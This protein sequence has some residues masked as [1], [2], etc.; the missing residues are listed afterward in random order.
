MAKQELHR[1][2]EN[3]MDNCLASNSETGGVGCDNMTM[4]V[5][6]LLRGRTK[7]E[8]YEEVARRASNGDG[9]CAPPEYGKSSAP[10]TPA[11][12]RDR[13]LTSDDGVAEFRGPGVHHSFE[14]SA[15]EFDADL[16][17]RFAHHPTGR[18]ILLG[19]GTEVLTD[20][21]D[22]EMFD[23]DDEDKDLESQV[24]R[25]QPGTAGGGG[26]GTK[27]S[28][29]GPS[30][31]AREGTPTA[32]TKAETEQSP[33]PRRQQTPERDSLE[34]DAVPEKLFTPPKSELNHEKTRAAT[35]KPPEQSPSPINET[36]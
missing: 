27:A 30:K 35:D 26:G 25:G 9:P 23:H 15:D 24:V 12:R 32:E 7:E 34:S 31:K 13:T 28:P 19:D 16:D 1:I 10:S 4:I 22:A 11:L 18:I 33:A 21:N 20:A 36:K 8:W 3:M 29:G 17:H 14:D 6:G 2:C 5:I